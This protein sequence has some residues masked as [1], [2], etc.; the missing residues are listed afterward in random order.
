MMPDRSAAEDVAQDA[1]L[2]ALEKEALGELPPV[3]GERR[4]WVTV[5]VRNIVRAY[6]RR[7]HA[8]S[9]ER[10]RERSAARSARIVETTDLSSTRWLDT[11]LLPA[12]ELAVRTEQVELLQRR[13]E[14]LPERTQTVLRLRFFDGLKPSEIAAQEGMSVSLVKSRLHR[15]LRRVRRELSKDGLG[16][17][18]DWLLGLALVPLDRGGGATGAGSAAASESASES[19]S[20]ATS[21]AGSLGRTRATS[22]SP[23]RA[24]GPNRARLHS[25]TL[26]AP[27]AAAASLLVLAG[28]HLSHADARGAFSRTA[29]AEGPVTAGDRADLEPVSSNPESGRAASA[30]T[31]AG[32]A[33]PVRLTIA[34]AKSGRPIPGARVRWIALDDLPAR[35]TANSAR[36]LFPNVLPASDDLGALAATAEAGQ[37][38]GDLT[39][40][41]VAAIGY[42]T[43]RTEHDGT[44]ALGREA[45]GRLHVLVECDG[46]GPFSRMWTPASGPDPIRIELTAAGTITLD[47]GAAAA[48][49]SIAVFARDVGEKQ[50]VPERFAPGAPTLRLEGLGQPSY[51][52]TARST[53]GAGG[54]AWVV[55]DLRVQVDPGENTDVELFPRATRTLAVQI[56]GLADT[57][58]GALLVA[59]SRVDGARL[60]EHAPIRGGAAAVGLHGCPMQ[61]YVEVDGQRVAARTIECAEPREVPRAVTIQ[62]PPSSLEIQFDGAVT[63]RAGTGPIELWLSTSD[64]TSFEARTVR[65]DDEASQD[66]VRFP[67]LEAGAYELWWTRGNR[68]GRLN[69]RVDS[70]GALDGAVTVVA[71][72]DAYAVDVPVPDG[73]AVATCLL[74]ASGAPL[75]FE[76]G[77]GGLASAL[78]P[79]GRYVVRSIGPDFGVR[80]QRFEVLGGA[81]VLGDSYACRSESVALQ[82]VAKGEP[83]RHGGALLSRTDFE[84]IESHRLRVPMQEGRGGGRWAVGRYRIELPDGRVGTFEVRAGTCAYEVE[85]R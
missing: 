32:D 23:A 5:V 6:G 84:G 9:I 14:A 19:A 62:L 68:S 75:G 22:S 72:A 18:S 41:E 83:V 78:L 38:D 11:S 63:A 76:F 13:L 55:R 65:L 80:E 33:G 40:E 69:V 37:L 47:R 42:R 30:G 56:E 43:R 48:S 57:A 4:A 54:H 34:E 25:A 27:T 51:V 45:R 26:I 61:L 21:G 35:P 66:G 50:A 52:V 59:E 49:D 28:L 3:E 20:G 70:K 1:L 77:D 58:A 8:R 2:I 17:R 29:A 60:E 39:D 64:S 53:P 15:G 10:R 82:L 24:F 73:T 85:V 7:R 67:H 71:A 31:A 74:S 36:R 44:V 16:D 12:D 79:D 81:R 46:Y